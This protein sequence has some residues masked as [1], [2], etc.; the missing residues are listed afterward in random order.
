MP[1]TEGSR[2]PADPSGY[3][4]R[5]QA[6]ALRSALEPIN[7]H[8]TIAGNSLGGWI[9]GWTALDWPQG[10]ERL[11]LIGAAGVDDPSGSDLSAA[12]ALSH[13]DV[14]AMKAFIARVYCHPPALPE[15]ALRGAVARLVARPAKTIV[16]QFRQEDLLDG[17]LDALSMPTDIIWGQCDKV[18]PSSM[19]ERYQSLIHGS[20]LTVLPECGHMPQQECPDA[21]RRVLFT[22]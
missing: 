6:R 17:K 7:A 5:A 18:L 1:G 12:Q 3:G 15:T 11:V 2:P 13:P 14:P 16:E 8:W 9:A 21:L 20:H 10:V 19:G 4:I 22:P